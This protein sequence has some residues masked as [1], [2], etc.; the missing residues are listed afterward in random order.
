MAAACYL[1]TC[2]MY[3]Y[4]NP[5]S[6]IGPDCIAC[7]SRSCLSTRREWMS[8]DSSPSHR[9]TQPLSHSA[10][11]TYNHSSNRSSTSH[12]KRIPSVYSHG[13]YILLQG[14]G[15][16]LAQLS[17]VLQP[18]GAP[19]PQPPAC[20]WPPPPWWPEPAPS[21]RTNKHHTQHTAPIDYMSLTWKM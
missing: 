6:A 3:A 4:H 18:S 16:Q 11:S 1:Y 19:R 10:T 7:S 8:L 2:L 5:P 17:S 15:R 14:R 20:P 9:P 13:T 12:S 21:E